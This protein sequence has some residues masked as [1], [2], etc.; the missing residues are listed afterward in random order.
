MPCSRAAA[1]RSSL[2]SGSGMTPA[3]T[4]ADFQA[5]SFSDV[6]Q[7]WF[8]SAPVEGQ[9]LGHL[10]PSGAPHGNVTSTGTVN[11]SV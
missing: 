2:V 3:V 11:R 4:R 1:Y 9:A 10:R 6:R 7:T 8:P 5:S